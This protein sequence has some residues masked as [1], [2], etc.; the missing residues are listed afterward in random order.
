MKLIQVEKT[1]PDFE[2]DYTLVVFPLL[3]FSKKSPQET[4]TEIGNYF[5]ETISDVDTFNVVNGFLNLKISDRYW[6]NFF[7]ESI[8]NKKFG[9]LPP[10][11]SKPILVEYS[12]PNTNK[13]LHLGHIRNNLLGY[14]ISEILKAN[15]HCVVKLNLINDRG[16]HICKSMLAWMKWGDGETPETSGM[17]G[18]HLVGKYYVMFDKK[19]KD[20]IAA[21][22]HRGFTDDEAY[23]Q[24]PLMKEAQ[25]ILQKWESA[26][27]EII[28]V[29][30]LMN[31]WA[32][33]GFNT[34]YERLGVDFD[35][36]NY[37]SKVYLH[38]KEI[39]LEG[40]KNGAFF[41]KDD[42]SVWA[43]LTNE[44]LDEK[45]LLRS[46]GTSVYITQDIGTAQRRFD[47]YGPEKMIYIV[48]NEQI[49]H[50]DVLKKVLHK[51]ERPW[52][53]KIFHLSYGMVELPHGRMKSREGTV[54]DADDLMDE[55]FETAKK[56]TEELGKSHDFNGEEK[57]SLYNMIS[58]GALKYFMLKVDPKKNML[59]NPEES[60]DFNGNTGPFIQYT[61]AR[62]QSIFRKAE[63][64]PEAFIREFDASG[65]T[66]LA[67]EKELIKLIYE[68]PQVIKLAGDN[69]NPAMIANY[70]FDLVKSY[71]H[72]YQETPILK[73]IEPEV[74]NFRVLLSWFA[75]LVIKKSMLLLGIDVPDKM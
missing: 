21:F 19:H 63:K 38:G 43:D 59:F 34:T 18:D 55:M 60:I 61:Y 6:M 73:R 50:F 51:L 7:N 13:P 66:M 9:F 44:G 58:L 74:A 56:T 25:G 32:L 40:V 47:E 53:D 29:W 28:T 65:V 23:A 46:D 68:F 57:Q 75:A 31:G 15:G 14:S 26:D 16:I 62:I 20:E 54:V 22:V 42:S 35:Q 71:N 5:V 11:H 70:C 12:S 37:E 33:E 67:A 4:A 41:Q 10:V 17:K 48:G 3:R 52:S 8:H 1:N 49:Y 36:V 27:E 64:E 69:L 45:L 72:Y 39:I 24:S 2:G 30:R